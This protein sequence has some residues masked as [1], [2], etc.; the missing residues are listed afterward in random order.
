MQKQ[1]SNIKELTDDLLRIYANT[2]N[3][4]IGLN[5]VKEKANTAG[6][7]LSGFKLLME[8]NDRTGKKDRKIE[9][10]EV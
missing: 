10:F 5:I 8:Y 9:F 6:K 4:K 3:K 7:I 2:E 1:P